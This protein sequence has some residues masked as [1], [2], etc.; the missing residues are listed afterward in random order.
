V[1]HGSQKLNDSYKVKITDNEGNRVEGYLS[2]YPPQ[3][4]EKK[5]YFHNKQQTDGGQRF[6]YTQPITRPEDDRKLVFWDK[7]KPAIIK[8]N[9]E[10]LYN[11]DIKD[12][13]LNLNGK[14]I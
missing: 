4:D 9:E 13:E 3:G 12:R 7:N 8:S 6:L 10:S 1:R 14:A 11:V 2:N 5:N